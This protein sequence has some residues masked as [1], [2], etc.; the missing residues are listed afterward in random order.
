MYVIT[1]PCPYWID[2]D[3]QK[4]ALPNAIGLNAVCK[5]SDKHPFYHDS[6]D[7]LEEDDFERPSDFSDQPQEPKLPTKV[8]YNKFVVSLCKV[9]TE[10]KPNK[11][12]TV[13]HLIALFWGFEINPSGDIKLYTVREA[14]PIE[15]KNHLIAC[16]AMYPQ[17]RYT[18]KQ[19]ELIRG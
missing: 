5:A 2:H 1:I 15:I 6:G 9:E 13:N 4:V 14:K 18:Y 11:L 16:K 7:D 19:Q 12:R 3:R 10:K 8:E 17:Y